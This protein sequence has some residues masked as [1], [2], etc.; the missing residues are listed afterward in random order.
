MTSRTWTIGLS[1]LVIAAVLLLGCGA[2]AES[3][4]EQGGSPTDSR[5]SIAEEIARA[6]CPPTWWTK[7]RLH[8]ACGPEEHRC[9]CVPPR[10]GTSPWFA[11]AGATP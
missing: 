3:R 6:D 8:A 11:R 5:P 2:G 9:R 1:L 4:S 10:V 7:C